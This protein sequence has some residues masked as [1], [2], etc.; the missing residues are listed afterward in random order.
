MGKEYTR[1]LN[2]E[3]YNGNNTSYNGKKKLSKKNSK[4]NS[5]SKS[6]K[7]VNKNNSTTEEMLEILNSDTE[8]MYESK[9]NN[10]KNNNDITPF[11]GEIPPQYMNMNINQQ[12]NMNQQPQMNSMAAYSP[13]NYDPMMLQQIAPLQINQNE[14]MFNNLN[15]LNKGPSIGSMMNNNFTSQFQN[16]ALDSAPM[17]QP[18]NIASTLGNNINLNNLNM[19]G[20]SKL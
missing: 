15:N 19:L 12:M 4:K 20:V 2:N 6:K 18:N 11:N 1:T 7:N 13:L 8:V 9:N 10:L 3:S 5:K 16:N 17:Q 14:D